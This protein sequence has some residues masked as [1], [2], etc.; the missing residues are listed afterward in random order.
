[1]KIDEAIKFLSS[2]RAVKNRRL[3]YGEIASPLE[4]IKDLWFSCLIYAESL[5]CVVGFPMT[6][7]QPV[8]D[9]GENENSHCCREVDVQHFAALFQDEFHYDESSK[10][11]VAFSRTSRRESFI[12]PSDY[13]CKTAHGEGDGTSKIYPFK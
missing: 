10:A 2:Q 6:L 11:V 5:L 7:S 12:S 13:F 4:Y 8:L 3:E 1:M 9:Q